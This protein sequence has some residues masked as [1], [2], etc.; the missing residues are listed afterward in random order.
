MPDSG[1]QQVPVVSTEP[2]RQALDEMSRQL[3][4]RLNEMVQEQ[5][6]RARLFAATQHSLSPLPKLPQAEQP[7]PP[8]PEPVTQTTRRPD[9]PPPPALPR[10]ARPKEPQSFAP[11]PKPQPQGLA[12]WL[13]PESAATQEAQKTGDE[14]GCGSVSTI[15]TIILLVLI[16]RS[17]T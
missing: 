1:D 11:T 2:Q 6:E 3:V 14:V 16:I 13:K 10:E 17:C 7:S 4:E 15:I 8:E 5:N 9:I 12:D